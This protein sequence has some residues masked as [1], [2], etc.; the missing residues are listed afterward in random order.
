VWV[1]CKLITPWDYPLLM[2]TVRP[3][4]VV[5]CY[6]TFASAMR[7]ACNAQKVQQ[8]SALQA[9]HALELPL[10]MATVRLDLFC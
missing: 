1:S 9:H 7:R 3:L 5:T 6:V 2:A 4:Y 10:L 8:Q